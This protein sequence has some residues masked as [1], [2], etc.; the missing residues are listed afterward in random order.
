MHVVGL[1]VAEYGFV[2]RRVVGFPSLETLECLPHEVF[3]DFGL[4][5]E[6]VGEQVPTHV[7]DETVFSERRVDVLLFVKVEVVHPNTGVPVRVGLLEPLQLL[8]SMLVRRQDG[9]FGVKVA[10][11]QK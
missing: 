2:G 10:R 1:E 11:L 5:Y 7:A 6:W 4:A 8:V 3:A 9:V